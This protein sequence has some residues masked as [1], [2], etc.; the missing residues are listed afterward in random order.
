MT[1]LLLIGL[2]AGW[3]RE[4]PK[5][6]TPPFGGEYLTSALYGINVSV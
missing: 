3:Y 1:L 5:L 6:S 2:N 4:V